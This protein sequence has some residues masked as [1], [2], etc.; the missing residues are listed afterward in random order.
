MRKLFLIFVIIFFYFGLVA[1]DISFTGTA[2]TKVGVNQNFQVKYTVNAQ[3]SNLS[4]G[5]YS[6][7]KLLSGPY[8]SSSTST[9]IYNGQVTTSVSY[10]YTYTFQANNIGNY[11]ISG[12]K[13]DINGKQYTSNAL[14]IEIQKDQVQTQQQSRRQTY[15]DPFED[16]FN[17]GQT[18]TQQ[19]KEITNEDLF[20]RVIPDK[21][22]LY[23]GEALTVSVKLYTRVDLSGL[24]DLEFPSFDAFYVEDLESATRLNFTKENY[25]GST[26]NVALIKRFL[27][28]PRVVGKVVIESCKA[29]CNVRQYIGGGFFAR[30]QDTPRKIQSPEISVNIKNLPNPPEN[31]TGAIGNFN[32][33][34]SQSEDTVNVNDAISLKFTVK[35]T[36]NFNMLEEPE[37]VWPKEFEVY[38]PIVTQNLKTSNSGIN[39]YKTWEYTIIPRYPGKFQLG[40][41]NFPYFDLNS[42]QYKILTSK[43]IKFAIRKDINDTKFENDYNYS[44]KTVEYIGEEDIRFVKRGNLN[45]KKNFSPIV[46]S[47][48]VWLLFLLPLIIF[49]IISLLWR[50]RIKENANIALRKVKLAGKTSKKRLKK[51]RKFMQQNKKTE[52]LKEVITALWGY[53]SDRLEIPIAELNKNKVITV[54]QALNTEEEIIKKF[55]ELIDKCEYSHFAPSSKETNLSTIYNEAVEVIE[56]LEQ[57]IR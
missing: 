22:N 2:P 43:E 42:H 3:G 19:T 33:D 53:T 56:K 5:N 37:I 8:T 54:L 38:D 55:I 9:Q 4:L 23:K 16:F 18:Q 28:Y 27:L 39:G 26:Y 32:I 10:S 15:Y 50:K 48:A 20:I 40:K 47:S 11:T 1:Q 41:I 45:L 14:N 24:T 52:F 6:G 35:G 25:N 21:T 17:T 12:A 34:L 51:A 29:E 49:I 57:K 44:Q 13:I 30:Y 7:L 31:F 36:G 46:N